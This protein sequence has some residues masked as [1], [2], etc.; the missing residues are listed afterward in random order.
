MEGF[1]YLFGHIQQVEILH[2]HRPAHT[3]YCQMMAIIP[4]CRPGQVTFLLVEQSGELLDVARLPVALLHQGLINNANEE[5]G[6]DDFGD[7]DGDNDDNDDE[8]D[9]DVDDNNDGD[10]NDDATCSP[11]LIASW[12][13]AVH[14]KR[15]TVRAT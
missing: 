1:P 13:S 8:D 9:N 10:N 12:I 14:T 15:Q 3:I 11:P 6:D 7:D 5:D 4:Y 2:Y